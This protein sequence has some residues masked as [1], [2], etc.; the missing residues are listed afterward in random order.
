MKKILKIAICTVF[1]LPLLQ[2]VSYAE[3][4]PKQKYCRSMSVGYINPVLRGVERVVIS[5]DVKPN[6][7]LAQEAQEK[8]PEPLRKENLE[9]MLKELYQQ[10]FYKEEGVVY[11]PT[12]GCHDR[13]NQ[14]VTVID[15]SNSEGKKAFYQATK[16]ENTLAVLLHAKIMPK[17]YWGLD[18]NSDIASFYL[19]QM[20]METD[21]YVE[22][23]YMTPLSLTL[24]TSPD[25]LQEFIRSG[26]KNKIDY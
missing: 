16:Q 9:G 3:E 1:V 15:Y 26:F 2:T 13:N 20:R 17:G 25:I 18:M 14:P 11:T 7:Y 8:L 5:V 6:A 24:S 10:R 21:D 4:K 22:N 23:R 19:S 12:K